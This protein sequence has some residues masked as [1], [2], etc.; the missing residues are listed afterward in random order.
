MLNLALF[1]MGKSLQ[2]IFL[3]IMWFVNNCAER[4]HEFNVN[5]AQLHYLID[6]FSFKLS[7]KLQIKGWMKI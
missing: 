4:T 1:Q 3:I 7:K 5:F 2:G 6:K